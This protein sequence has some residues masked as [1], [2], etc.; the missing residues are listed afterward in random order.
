MQPFDEALNRNFVT[1]ETKVNESI[2]TNTMKRRDAPRKAA[3]YAESAFNHYATARETTA[4]RL[5]KT[6]DVLRQEKTL[7]YGVLDSSPSVSW[8]RL[9]VLWQIAFLTK[10]QLQ[11]SILKRSQVSSD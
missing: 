3:Q 1:Y 8:A 5:S 6:L 9:T 11:L 2:C 10:R 4:E 7:V